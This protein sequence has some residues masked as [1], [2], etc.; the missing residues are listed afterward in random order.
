MAHAHVCMYVCMYVCICT[1][2]VCH[3]NPDMLAVNAFCD[4]A[5]QVN[6]MTLCMSAPELVLQPAP[7]LVLAVNVGQGLTSLSCVSR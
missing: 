5:K 4:N 2:H 3:L 7:V 6:S 1:L